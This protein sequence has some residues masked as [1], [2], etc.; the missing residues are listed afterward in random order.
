MAGIA[1][2]VV[3]PVDRDGHR[4]PLRLNR[5]HQIIA[6][7]A[8]RAEQQRRRSRLRASRRIQ[9]RGRQPVANVFSRG[10]C[11]WMADGLR[12]GGRIM[13]L[14]RGLAGVGSWE[15][16]HDVPLVRDVAIRGIADIPD[17]VHELIPHAIL[18]DWAGSRRR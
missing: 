17:A 14:N 3:P 6:D 9:W 16:R 1:D 8:L 10:R 18:P 12:A 7:D 4:Q 5:Q 13:G 2:T 15:N 11:G